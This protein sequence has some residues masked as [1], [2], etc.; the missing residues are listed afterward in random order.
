VITMALILAGT[1]GLT[2][3]QLQQLHHELF[4]L[5]LELSGDTHTITSARCAS[6][7]LL[8]AARMAIKSL[9]AEDG[10][11]PASAW[12]EFPRACRVLITC[13]AA[14][15]L[16]PAAFL[17]R[18]AR[19]LSELP[20]R[21]DSI[22]YE[23]SELH[24]RFTPKDHLQFVQLLLSSACC[25]AIRDLVIQPWIT[26]AAADAVLHACKQL[27]HA[28]LSVF[29]ERTQEDPADACW[30]PSADLSHITG[31]IKLECHTP[32]DLASLSTAS[33]LQ[34]LQLIAD[35]SST[36]PLI[37]LQAISS[38]TSLHSLRLESSALEE[39][40]SPA[41]AQAF[42]SLQ[43]LRSF[44][45]RSRW[46]A[47]SWAALASLPSLTD[48][49]LGSIKIGISAASPAAAAAA[50]AATSIT[51][52]SLRLEAPAALLRGCL[53]RQLP[54]LRR[55]VTWPEGAGHVQHLLTGLQG[56]AGLREL[57][58]GG[59][60][61]P[62]AEPWE[63]QL[64]SQLPALQSLSI[65]CVVPPDTLLADIA[66]CSR[67]TRLVLDNQSDG[68]ITATGVAALRAGPCGASL[69]EVTLECCSFQAGVELM[70]AEL[71]ALRKVQLLWLSDA[72]MSEELPLGGAGA[73][74]AS[75]EEW[76]TAVAGHLLPVAAVAAGWEVA[77]VEVVG[78]GVVGTVVLARARARGCC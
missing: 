38:L 67:L 65:A 48:I 23:R 6:K 34:H 4:L 25:S 7:A 72:P 32:I 33:K 21:C 74:A 57:W 58:L 8:D 12:R 3:P 77:E 75:Q 11:I 36:A 17:D 76:C 31:S 69:Q 68:H 61:Q 24:S 19:L 35:T 46:P 39:G 28:Q 30:C 60:D 44:T 18:V 41:Q 13:S 22:H 78:P 54:H 5:I 73:A 50:A 62:E 70:G 9:T 10:Y 66:G 14:A 29:T 2:Q 47:A 45:S 52:R 42:T 43:Q 59:D 64:L 37:N 63:H 26:T 1:S 15:H 49:N 27:Q 16:T 71:P 55:L 53:A 56:H 40:V 20:E 51:C